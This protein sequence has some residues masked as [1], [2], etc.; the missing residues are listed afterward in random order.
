[1]CPFLAPF[2]DVWPV[3]VHLHHMLAISSWQAHND[4]MYANEDPP[5]EVMTV[6]EVSRL[7]VGGIQA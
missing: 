2:R 3:K 7:Y 5:R 1:M 6:D 4:N